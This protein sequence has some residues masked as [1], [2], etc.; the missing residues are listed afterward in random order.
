M[1]HLSIRNFIDSVRERIVVIDQKYRIIFAN[2]SFCDNIEIPF[3][4]VIGNYCHA[5][6][7]H[8]QRPCAE[9]G[10]SCAVNRVFETGFA[11]KCD[12]C[13]FGSHAQEVYANGTTHPLQQYLA[14][15]RFAL[16]V[17]T[18]ESERKE[19]FDAEIPV[20]NSN[21]NI[22]AREQK[23][24]R[25]LHDF[26]DILSPIITYSDI[27]ESELSVSSP[28]R[29]YVTGISKSAERAM[30]FVKKFQTH[31]ARDGK[32]GTLP[33]RGGRILF[34]D[35]DYLIATA[36]KRLMEKFGYQV[37]MKI[38]SLEALEVFKRAPKS[39]DLA[40]LD[41]QMPNMNGDVLAQELIKVRADIPVIICTGLDEMTTEKIKSIGI[42]DIINKP[43]TSIEL[44]AKIKNAIG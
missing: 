15:K 2:K 29:K 3:D 7:R 28:L 4:N 5:L 17:C 16:I 8:K 30:D 25:L 14:D 35:D 10:S 33:A 13:C 26:N 24:R 32:P 43:V 31:Q 38:C 19:N 37:D 6:I 36:G 1:T 20:V 42:I 34:V 11:G 27:L 22:D 12:C 41:L 18:L 39:Y 21:Q 23:S 9:T 44:S 40:I